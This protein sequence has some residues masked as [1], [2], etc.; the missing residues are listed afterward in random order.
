MQVTKYFV[1]VSGAYIGGFAG[2]E[3]PAGAIEVP[4]APQDARQVW[5]GNEWSPVPVDV[6]QEVSRYQAL[7]ALH[8]AG[9]LA[10]VEAMMEDPA[11]DQLTVLAWK[12]ALVFKRHSPMVLNMAQ[13]L[14]WTDGQVDDL[15]ITASTIE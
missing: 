8:L 11:T 6:P 10:A 12:N 13:A 14:G 3:P 7:A 5:Q 4:T 1:D 9:K 15:F 2:A